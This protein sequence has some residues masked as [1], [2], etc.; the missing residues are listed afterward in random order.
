M[1][2]IYY[3]LIYFCLL[4]IYLDSHKVNTIMLQRCYRVV[5]GLQCCCYAACS[6]LVVTVG[7]FLIYCT[8]CWKNKDSILFYSTLHSFFIRTIL[9]E[10]KP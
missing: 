2:F 7:L 4:N 5:A 9:S 8:N 1:I 6:L 3:K 10:Q